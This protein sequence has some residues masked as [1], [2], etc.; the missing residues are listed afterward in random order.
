[1]DFSVYINFR[2]EPHGQ[3]GIGRSKNQKHK[4]TSIIDQLVEQKFMERR[5]FSIYLC[6]ISGC[7]TSNIEFGKQ[8]PQYYADNTEIIEVDFYN[9]TFYSF[10]SNKIMIGK[11]NI[12]LNAS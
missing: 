9:E 11:Y 5:L 4:N 8:Y 6:R 7:A 1:M 10:E 12:S 2:S 3:L